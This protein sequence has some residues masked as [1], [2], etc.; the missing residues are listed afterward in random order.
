MELE[1]DD[2]Y[3]SRLAV[4]DMKRI[5]AENEERE[6]ERLTFERLKRKFEP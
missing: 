4:E 3:N 2:E 5:Q 6:R 1:S